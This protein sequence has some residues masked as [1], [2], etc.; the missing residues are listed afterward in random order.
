M[1]MELLRRRAQGIGLKAQKEAGRALALRPLSFNF[2]CGV[3]VFGHCDL[4]EYRDL[5]IAD[6][7]PLQ[8]SSTPVLQYSGISLNSSG[9]VIA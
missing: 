6:L 9:G 7:S 2:E 8:Y 5:G 1:L 3:L 4:L